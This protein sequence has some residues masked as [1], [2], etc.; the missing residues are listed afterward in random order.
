MEVESSSKKAMKAKIGESCVKNRDCF[1]KKCK[2]NKCVS[3]SKTLKKMN[4]K[5]NITNNNNTQK[6]KKKK[7]GSYCDSELECYTNRC[8]DSKCVSKNY[9]P[10]LTEPVLQRL[11]MKKREKLIQFLS[12]YFKGFNCS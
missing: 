11:S 7:I 12:L 8:V 6:I 4:S 9:E 1:S 2:N 5:S 3:K 10:E